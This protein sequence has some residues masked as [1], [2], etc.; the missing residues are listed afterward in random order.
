VV[1]LPRGGDERILSPHP[2]RQLEENA[3]MTQRPV[4]VALLSILVSACADNPVAEPTTVATCGDGTCDAAENNAGCPADCPCSKCVRTIECPNECPAACGD[5]SCDADE[6]STSCPAD[7]PAPECGDGNCDDGE[8][9]DSCPGDCRP[10]PACGD[11]R[12]D[13]TETSATCPK[14]CPAPCG[15]GTC[16]AATETGATCPKDC[17]CDYSSPPG[18]K[19]LVLHYGKFPNEADNDTLMIAAGRP[20][21]EMAFELLS[22]S[23]AGDSTTC[24]A[25]S[26]TFKAYRDKGVRLAKDLGAADQLACLLIGST[27]TYHCSNGG[28]PLKK[29]NGD[30]YCPSPTTL[31]KKCTDLPTWRRDM[32]S[33]CVNS[34]D[35]SRTQCAADLME[36]KIRSGWDYFSVDELS[37]SSMARFAA[38]ADFGSRLLDLLDKLKQ[39]GLS[40]RMAF[41]FSPSTTNFHNLPSITTDNL[42]PFAPLFQKCQTECRALMFEAYQAD[43][44]YYTNELTVGNINAL[45]SRLE[46]IA[47]GTNHVS[48]IGLGIAGG[49]CY[50]QHTSVMKQL[51]WMAWWSDLNTQARQWRGFSTYGLSHVED[52]TWLDPSA[53]AND[54]RVMT[55]WWNTHP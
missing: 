14:D 31:S 2:S 21:V 43:P 15:D 42:K 41:W 1:P 17:P 19:A 52:C 28:K 13:L 10:L 18:D 24:K 38:P 49:Y 34:A 5:G 54:L 27:I 33:P 9:S 40:R 8:T 53:L 20:N 3:P 26:G 7:C 6:T 46:K 47:P 32:V 37:T 4:A 22:C 39:K 44:S 11:G 36:T 29:S 51:N 25:P 45:A 16:D 12:C 55:D 50:L 30:P 23:G 35:Q 48:L